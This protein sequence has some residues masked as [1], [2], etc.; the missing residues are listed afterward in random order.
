MLNK[1]IKST[2]KTLGKIVIFWQG[3][4]LALFSDKPPVLF[5]FNS[6]LDIW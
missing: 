2:S 4:S 3:L 6:T 5:L 1:C